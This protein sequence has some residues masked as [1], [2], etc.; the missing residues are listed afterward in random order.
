MPS[1][2]ESDLCKGWAGTSQQWALRYPEYV[3]GAWR[4]YS[5]SQGK[6][7]TTAPPF[8]CVLFILRVTS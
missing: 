5:D 4:E 1:P 6:L 3:Q 2:T 8:A 7:P